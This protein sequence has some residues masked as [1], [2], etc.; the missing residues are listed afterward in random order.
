MPNPHDRRKYPAR[1]WIAEV[2]VP[3]GYNRERRMYMVLANC[4]ADARRE[5]WNMLSVAQLYGWRLL[6]ITEH[7]E[8]TYHLSTGC[9]G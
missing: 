7:A 5:L 3:V 6:S 4:E 9:E 1:L 2:T 8:P